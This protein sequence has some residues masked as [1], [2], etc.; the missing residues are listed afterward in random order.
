MKDSKTQKKL[1]RT[2]ARQTI[3]YFL[4]YGPSLT[5]ER[6]VPLLMLNLSENHSEPI[7]IAHQCFHHMQ[8]PE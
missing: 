2:E 8:F 1:E 6:L 4:P 7:M 5:P 3:H